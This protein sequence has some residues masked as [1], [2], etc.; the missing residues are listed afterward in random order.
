M[1]VNINFSEPIFGYIFEIIIWRV[2]TT[3]EFF[4]VFFVTQDISKKVCRHRLSILTLVIY[5]GYIQM[6]SFHWWPIHVYCCNIIGTNLYKNI[7]TFSYC[8]CCYISFGALTGSI[9]KVIKL[10]NAHVSWKN[11]ISDLS[12]TRHMARWK[13]HSRTHG[14]GHA[15][16]TS[17]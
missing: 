14:C 2:S 9:R 1:N 6:Y 15:F 4:G 8:I 16:L 7:N 5:I 10:P 3:F 12:N 13:R 17:S 11:G